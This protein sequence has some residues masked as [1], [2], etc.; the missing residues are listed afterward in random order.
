[1][2]KKGKFKHDH[3]EAKALGL[4]EFNLL[5]NHQFTVDALRQATKEASK[6]SDKYGLGLTEADMVKR[7]EL[8]GPDLKRNGFPKFQPERRPPGGT[9]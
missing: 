4:L 8:F 2:W 7:L 1:M 6:V 5:N 9:P 3:Q